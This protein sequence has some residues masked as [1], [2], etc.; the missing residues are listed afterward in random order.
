MEE[1]T[2]PRRVIPE[3]DTTASPPRRANL[4][5]L[6]LLT[7]F[8]PLSLDLYLPALPALAAELAATDSS[9]Q[10]TLSACMVGLALGQ[11]VAGTLSDRFGRKV[12]LVAGLA[13]Y[14]AL[15]LGCAL[16]ST[17]EAMVVLRLLQGIAGGSSMVIAR[18]IVRDSY[19]PTNSARAFSI[20]MLASGVAP[21][22]A[23]I[24]GSQL[25]LAT[26]WRGLFV[27]LAVLVSGLL[28]AAIWRIQ[29]SLPKEHRHTGGLGRWLSQARL[30]FTDP[31]F[32]AAAA[33]QCLMGAGMFTFI[34]MSSFVFQGHYGFNAQAYGW[35][36]AVISL[37]I[38]AFSRISAWA[39]DRTTPSRVIG[40]GVGISMVGAGG[41]LVA[42]VLAAPA[43]VVVIWLFLCIASG[44]LIS[45]NCYA[46]AL[47]DQGQRSG[48]A[49]G[50]L[51][52]MR[53][54]LGAV[55]GPIVSLAG[56]TVLA[57]GIAMFIVTA[58]MAIAH[59]VAVVRVRGF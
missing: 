7:A 22:A 9:A 48:T 6:G 38:V 39:A 18:A 2:D 4:L 10:L 26:S 3:H 51:G 5:L 28:W 46:L 56:A 47:R 58:L 35:M 32:G 19:G 20:L 40:W 17:I 12:P 1:R 55:M 21:V 52:L 42:I 34:A 45:P 11:V 8:G 59:W 29:E 37:G 57:M 16:V 14:V 27:V 43:W 30:L 36:F 23:P 53:F 13:A 54:G 33:I 15:S 25:L 41:L 31:V 50:I 49:S 44:G 24:L